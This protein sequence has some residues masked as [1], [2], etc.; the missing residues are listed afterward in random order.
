MKPSVCPYFDFALFLTAVYKKV[1]NIVFWQK[2]YAH[3]WLY[4]V[5]VR[6]LHLKNIKDLSSKSVI[7]WYF[8]TFNN[9]QTCQRSEGNLSAPAEGSH[10][11]IHTGWQQIGIHPWGHFFLGKPHQQV[12]HHK[13]THL[14]SIQGNHKETTRRSFFEVH[15]CSR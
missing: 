9:R 12:H 5:C 13:H 4:Y 7:M 8:N 10:S 1:W 6:S 14:T 15:L 2:S 11:W 3:Y